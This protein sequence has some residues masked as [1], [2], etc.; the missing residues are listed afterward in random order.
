M[1]YTET[2]YRKIG[3]VAAV[4][5]AIAAMM[6]PGAGIAST[7]FAHSDNGVSSSGNVHQSIKQSNE[8]S[9][10]SSGSGSTSVHD[11]NQQNFASNTATVDIHNS[12]SD[13]KYHGNDNSGISHS[14]NVK[15]SIKQ[16]NEISASSSGGPV[17]VFDNNQQNFASNDASV[18]ISN[19]NNNCCHPYTGGSSI[20]HSG[21]VKQS[22]K[23]ENEISA[24]SSGGPVSVFDNN[25]QNFASN[26]ASVD[27]SNGGSNVGGG[28]IS[29]SGN[30]KQSIDQSNEITATST[31]PPLTALWLMAEVGSVSVHDNNQQN[32]AD[33]NATVSISN[34]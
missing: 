22:I 7:A 32:F 16:E 34:N 1:N 24:S 11:N 10:S 14:G 13:S 5:I 4:A 3:I 27:L 19:N 30:V 2:N 33:N 28:S 23:Q 26:T 6:I 21:N 17:S 25:Q 20:S 15:Q 9:A 18:S 8:I 31:S 29:H 12:G